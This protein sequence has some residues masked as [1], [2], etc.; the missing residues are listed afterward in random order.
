MFTM[1]N[2]IS[3]VG[4]TLLGVILSVVFSISLFWGFLPGFLFLFFVSLIKGANLYDLFNFATRGLLKTKDVMIILLLVGALLPVWKMSGTIDGMVTLILS[5]ISVDYFYVSAFLSTLLV[6]MILGTC[7]GSL[8]VIGIPLI[9]AAFTIGVSPEITAGALVS[10]AFVGDRSSP[11]SSANQLL[12]STLEIDRKSFQRT[13]MMSGI[14]AFIL[15]FIFYIWFDKKIQ[16]GSTI[17][18]QEGMVRS[19]FFVLPVISLL[20]LAVLKINI[21]TCFI[22]S[23]MTGIIVTITSVGVTDELL[24]IW[25]GTEEF[26]GGVKNMIPLVAFIGLAGAYNGIVEKL[27]IF[28]VFLTKWMDTKKDMYS[29]T[30]RTMI[31]TLFISLLASNQTLP[32]ILTGRTFMKDWERYL[33]KIQLARVMAD[34]SMLFAGIIPWSVLAIMCSTILRI[35]LIEYLPFAIFLWVLP[36]ITLLISYIMSF[37]HAKREM[38]NYLNS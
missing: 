38:K 27:E 18:L 11:F 8:S 5:N 21:K 32:I 19:Y 24:T 35:P 10:G 2:S 28:Q 7:V 16:I 15:S 13:I 37:L 14:I 22:V 9:G 6:S 33:S 34:S 23:I 25:N 30:W 29:M 26:G 17:F 20:I 1:K 4:I 12:S 31:A 36:L 3:I